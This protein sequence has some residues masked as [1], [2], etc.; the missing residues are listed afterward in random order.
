MT[1]RLR[2]GMFVLLTMILFVVTI[3]CSAIVGFAEEFYSITIEYLFQDET[4]AYD[5]YVAVYAADTDVNINVRNPVI[6]GY[7]AKVSP[8][9]GADDA[10][11]TKISVENIS[12]NQTIKVYYIPDAVPYRVR[13]FFQN[14]QDD[15]F[16][17]DLSFD[18][19]YY[20]KM[21]YTGDYPK[22]LDELTFNGFTLMPHEFDRI[23]ADGSTVYE[24]YY[25]R[26]Y[27]LITFDLDGGYGVE[28]VYAKFGS[29]YNIPVP[30]KQGYAFVGWAQTNENGE[31]IDAQGNVIT[32]EE[33]KELATPFTSGTVL[34]DNMYYKAVWEAQ[35]SKYTVIYRIENADDT[36]YSFAYS[37]E[38]EALSGSEV[39]GEDDWDGTLANTK[40][41][42]KEYYTFESA[43]TKVV[44]GDGSTIINV[45]Y[46]RNVYKLRFYYARKIGDTYSV[47][48]STDNFSTGQSDNELQRMNNVYWTNISGEPELKEGFNSEKYTIGTEPYTDSSGN[49]ISTFY[50]IEFEAKYGSFIGDFWPLDFIEPVSM[51][52]DDAAFFATWASPKGSY[53]ANHNPLNRNIKSSYRR[54]DKK[55]LME[56]D[57][58]VRN[59]S[60]LA[61]WAVKRN[62]PV[63]WTYKL[64]VPVLDEN[65]EGDYTYLGKKYKHFKDYEM[66]TTSTTIDVQTATELSGFTFYDKIADPVNTGG[67]TYED[68]AGNQKSMDWYTGRFFYTRDSYP[69]EFENGPNTEKTEVVPYEK[70]LKEYDY[71]PEYTNAD[72]SQFYEFGGWYTTA[73]C[74]EGTEFD[75]QKSTMPSNGIVLYAKWNPIKHDV[76]FYNDLNKYNEDTP[77]A[78]SLMVEHNSTIP[79]KNIPARTKPSKSAVF[80]GWYY[81]NDDGTTVIFDPTSMPITKSMKLY[82]EWT[83]KETAKY[84]INYVKKGTDEAVAASSQGSAFVSSTRTFQAKGGSDLNEEGWW[85][86]V[87]SHSILI[88]PDEGENSFTFQYIK[89]ESVWYT[90]KYVNAVTGEELYT[91][92][93]MPS[94][95][96]VV[97]EK[98]VYVKGYIVDS[99]T[100]S[101]VLAASEKEDTD[102]AKAEELAK[103]VII[104]YYTENTSSTIY[105]VNHFI[106]DVDDD[107]VYTLYRNQNFIAELNVQV[108]V[109]ELVLTELTASGF[110]VDWDKSSATGSVDVTPDDGSESYVT[111]N[112]YYEREKYPYV[113]NYLEYGTDRSFKTSAKVLYTKK[114]TGDEA[115]PV[116]KE[117]IYTPP[118][119]YKYE[120]EEYV[121]IG[122]GDVAITIRVEENDANIAYNII[123]VYYQRRETFTIDYDA[124]CIPQAPSGF[125]SDIRLSQSQEIV[126]SINDSLGS[127]VL[128]YPQEKYKFLGW[129]N[130][131]EGTGEPI[132]TELTID[133]KNISGATIQE[134][135]TFYAV[136]VPYIT[137]DVSYKYT[138]DGGNTWKTT[139]VVEGLSATFDDNTMEQKKILLGS[140]ISLSASTTNEDYEFIGWYVND[141]GDAIEN[142]TP[143]PTHIPTGDVKYVARFL[144][145]TPYTIY[146]HYTDR[147]GVEKTYKKTG[148][149]PSGEFRL[150]EE[151]AKITAVPHESVFG[152]DLIWDRVEIDA[153]GT[154]ADVYSRNEAKTLSLT[155]PEFKDNNGAE[156]T[157]VTKTGLAFK[158]APENVT[159]DRYITAPSA[160]TVPVVDE[161]G[162]P[163]IDEST[164][165]QKTV[166]QKF[167]YWAIKLTKDVEKAGGNFSAAKEYNRCYARAFNYAIID[168][169]WIEPVYVN[170]SDYLSDKDIFEKKQG[171]VQSSLNFLGYTRDQWSEDPNLDEDTN[172][173]STDKIY[174]DFIASYQY[175]NEQLVYDVY[176]D[177]T[178]QGDNGETKTVAKLVKKHSEN[179]I[180]AGVVLEVCG[181]IDENTA[182]SEGFADK[183]SDYA[184]NALSGEE[185]KNYIASRQKDSNIMY[186]KNFIDTDNLGNKN[187]VHYNCSFSNSDFKPKK[188]GTY[189]TGRAYQILRVHSFMK[190]KDGTVVLSDPVYI[191]TYQIASAAK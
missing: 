67:Y 175:H 171:N 131:P 62:G 140:S 108:N 120:N 102:E 160:R 149:Y 23:A 19:G 31:F 125:N 174:I 38:V 14:I 83:S 124:V 154:T 28:P 137:A 21:G 139:P 42:E 5:P 66:F 93:E 18:T 158:E 71:I 121:R 150:T 57:A 79:S 173:N 24:L 49:L 110:L 142:A 53:Y 190:L 47:S 151:F 80:V 172:Y 60:F 119:T 146:Y 88:D 127:K 2:A 86:T 33:A 144:K 43:Q 4:T 177:E 185:L 98:A 159:S 73:A 16:T 181:T 46:K 13:Y 65:E 40:E 123:N 37:K 115:Q 20:E 132:T 34:N 6:P 103:N 176:E 170:E 12:E 187:D 26:N 22:D 168:N 99:V 145:V 87:T 91:H 162:N 29:N 156:Y 138:D 97:T 134:D 164:N 135:V 153:Q 126:E 59:I 3:C 96:G 54:L 69:L 85:P 51:S 104:F 180:D 74:I 44:E 30:T 106:Q 122:E 182:Q 183:L 189:T 113:V 70:S 111:I 101:S 76:T 155:Y 117:I 61:Y 52:G 167:S 72:L 179:V 147:N 129:Y 25:E 109:Q 56:N 114:Y 184:A 130:N 27:S 152:V 90:V 32:E 112:I 64:Y 92:K 55:I 186:S 78:E 7:K 141:E 95:S 41:S 163:I 157:L 58:S 128:S 94:K 161:E 191:N 100:K 84:S 116:G 136:F 75:L 9:S 118:K 36:N 81:I 63:R 35:M 50:Y 8:E 188:D 89:K 15:S 45:Y 148:K 10:L 1:K 11:F 105:E 107:S 143:A 82:A 133:P 165:S 77:L 169:L 178:V 39:T 68:N 17:E 166:T 48:Y